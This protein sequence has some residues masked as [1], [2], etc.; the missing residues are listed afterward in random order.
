MESE[1]V[2]R[3]IKVGVDHTQIKKWFDCQPKNSWIR[4]TGRKVQIS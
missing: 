3:M 2:E 1:N 4:R